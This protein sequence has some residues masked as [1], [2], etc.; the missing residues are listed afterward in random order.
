MKT[1]ERRE[2]DMKTRRSCKRMISVILCVAVA[3][4]VVSGGVAFA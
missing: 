2:Y 1:A 4:T 3:L